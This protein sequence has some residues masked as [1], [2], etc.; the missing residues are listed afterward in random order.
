MASIDQYIDA[1]VVL[2]K[3]RG[4]DLRETQLSAHDLMSQCANLT[5][6]VTREIF[7]QEYHRTSRDRDMTKVKA[8]IVRT[9]NLCA[10]ALSVLPEAPDA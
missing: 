4:A 8:A 1:A 9:M 5:A 6:G 7:E 3:Q 2:M 10:L